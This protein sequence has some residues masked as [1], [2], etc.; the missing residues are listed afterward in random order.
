MPLDTYDNLKLEIIKW[1]KRDDLDLDIDTFID[2]AETEMFNNTVENLKVRGQ[3][4]TYNAVLS[5]SV[6]TL[7]LP[8]DYISSRSVRITV[9]DDSRVVEYAAP[10]FLRIRDGNGIPLFFTITDQIEF[11]VIAE[12]DYAFEMKYI[13]KP[14]ALSSSNQTNTVLTN[15][16]NIYLFGSLWSLKQRTEEF[17]E[18][19]NYYSQFINAIR[20]A[21]KQYFEGQFGPAPVMR[22]DGMTP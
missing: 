20:G 18:S 5:T 11:D 3:E 13:G 8:S 10:E 21:N 17:E 2:L 16:P 22:V 19:A 4:S 9:G 15:N 7:A 6:R 14:V 1:S 12:A